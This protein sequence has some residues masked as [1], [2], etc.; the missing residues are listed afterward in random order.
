MEKDWL[1]VI[2][3]YVQRVLAPTQI[4]CLKMKDLLSVADANEVKDSVN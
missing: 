3:V 1:E 2:N 4:K